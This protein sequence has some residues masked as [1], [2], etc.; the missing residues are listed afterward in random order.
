MK[1][2]N[3]TGLKNLKDKQY[4]NTENNM[5]L[6]FTS[7]T[8]IFHYFVVRHLGNFYHKCLMRYSVQ[9]NGSVNTPE[10]GQM[11]TQKY[12]STD[13]LNLMPVGSTRI[14]LWFLQSLFLFCSGFP[15]SVHDMSLFFV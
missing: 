4:Q 3:Q 8:D 11:T 14:C 2:I 9:I 10:P 7:V 15:I 5:K 12:L 1:N 13:H 6:I